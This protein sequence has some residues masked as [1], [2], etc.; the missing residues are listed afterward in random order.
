MRRK[1]NHFYG[2][3]FDAVRYT[4]QGRISAC[5]DGVFIAPKS[6]LEVFT[7]GEQLVITDYLPIQRLFPPRR[8]S[9]R[10]YQRLAR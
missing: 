9:R 6:F 7:W 1:E 8:F 4:L 10:R 5:F 2:N 3:Y